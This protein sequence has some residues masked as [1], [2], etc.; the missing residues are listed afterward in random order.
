MQIFFQR[1]SVLCC[2]S[3][4]ASCATNTQLSPPTLVEIDSSNYRTQ[5]KV[6]VADWRFY[7]AEYIG[8]QS[9]CFPKITGKDCTGV[10]DRT[11]YGNVTPLR[12]EEFF[13]ISTSSAGDAAKR[14]DF[15]NMVGADVAI[16]RGYQYFTVVNR[17]EN[18]FCFAKYSASTSGVSSGGMYSGR[19][20][21]NKDSS[22]ATTKAI[23]MIAFND[24]QD[25]AN[26]VF[27]RVPNANDGSIR[28]KPYAELYFN[29]M[30]GLKYEDF[31]EV[32]TKTELDATRTASLSTTSNAWKTYYL[33]AGV[34][35]DFR[36]KYGVTGTVPFPV[37]DAGEAK[38][39]SAE[40]DMMERNRAN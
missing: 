27:F 26:G 34:S 29:T 33:A 2:T 31:N 25:L 6:E 30:T 11:P 19:T 32:S 21:L 4:L 23:K 39:K 28:L 7:S 24:P 36:A 17:R 40:G 15:I 14:Q 38:R 16:Q 37:A 18:S 1:L 12:I 8:A 35:K 10:A 20:T 9:N 22:C 5:V 3:L 13:I